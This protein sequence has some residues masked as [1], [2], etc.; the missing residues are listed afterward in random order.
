MNLR[1]LRY[2]VAA[3]FVAG[4]CLVLGWDRR[5]LGPAGGV[6]ILGD[7]P[8]HPATEV[9][10]DDRP[11]FHIDPDRPWRIDLGRGSGMDGL[12]TVT[13]DQSGRVRLYQHTEA[14]LHN[15]IGLPWETAEGRI[16]PDAVAAVLA[17]AASNR[18]TELQHKYLT[19]VCDGTQWILRVRQGENE[20]AVYFDTHFPDA[21]L[22]FAAKLDEI[23]AADVGAGLRWRPVLGVDRP[24]PQRELW[25]S[26]NR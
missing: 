7:P 14:W 22:R 15:E 11:V 20:K 8:S 23:V 3:T 1:R 10:P 4:V 18:L 5:P 17:A 16:S 26:I 6:R 2:L 13:L 21:V 9:V 25:E 12:D 24:G 19:N